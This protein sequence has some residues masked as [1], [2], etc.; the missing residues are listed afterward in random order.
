M[1]ADDL[2]ILSETE[3]G[4][5]DS[6]NR[7]SIY[8]E[9]W[10]L[11]VNYNKSKTMI[12]H[13][14]VTKKILNIKLNNQP[15]EEV[16]QFRY[17][18]NIISN[19]GN[20]KQNDKYLKLKGQ[21][22]S[23]QLMKLV[24]RYMKPSNNISLFEKIIEPILLYNCEITT[25]Y[26]P[27]KWN[28]ENF[29]ENMWN[30][31]FEIN[32]VLN[33]YIRQILGVDKKTSKNG[34]LSEC[35]KFPL[36]LKVYVQIVRY[37][38]RLHTLDNEY[39]QELLKVELNQRKNGNDSWLKIVG[40]LIKYINCNIDDIQNNNNTLSLGKF[41]YEFEKKIKDMYKKSWKE[42]I[43]KSFNESKIEFLC[44]YKRNF[45]FESYI[46]NLNFDN[47]KTVSRFRLSNHNLPIERLRYDNIDREERLCGICDQNLVGDEN[48]YMIWCQNYQL[49]KIREKFLSKVSKI[50]PE[51]TQLDEKNI[52][53]YCL[54]L[55]DSNIH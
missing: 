6:L 55:A 17:L 37:W 9:K 5:K 12:F 36:C 15:L 11:K 33:N 46:D 52:I 8:N 32:K 18:G 43:N 51:I 30:T 20:F 21:R 14:R 19:T 25:A 49:R 24:G 34:I 16:N 50:I 7:L 44:E 38:I 27:K 35:G 22:A 54:V 40:F 31:K 48:H 45:K 29:I 4:L 41:R 2:L 39:M 53:K 23:Y 47:R 13:S 26:I 42:N 28:F 3:Q 10:L 1:Y